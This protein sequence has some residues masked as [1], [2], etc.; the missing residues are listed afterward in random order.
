MMITEKPLSIF[1]A[2]TVWS[3]DKAKLSLIEIH[4]IRRHLKLS[5]IE[6][7]VILPQ[8]ENTTQI[9]IL[10]SNV[11]TLDGTV[12]S[13]CHENRPCPRLQTQLHTSQ[14]ASLVV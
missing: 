12:V 4:P 8:D 9:A 10:P 6:I 11:E 13:T 7:E 14:V 5:G 3:I 2:F 1:F